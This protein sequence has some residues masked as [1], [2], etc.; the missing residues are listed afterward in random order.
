MNR[1]QAL[2]LGAL[3]SAGLA[4]PTSLH[5]AAPDLALEIAPVS[6]EVSPKRFLKTIGYNGQVPGPLLR[7]AEGRPVT[8]DVVNH[9]DAAEVVHWH[10]LSIPSEVDGAME[11]GTLMIAPGAQARYTFTPTP[12]GLRWYHSHAFAGKDLKRG[13]FSGQH[14]PMWID[15]KQNAGRYDQEVFLTL[16]DWDARMIGSD[17]GS[18]S[19]EY[20]VST[21][22]GRT[23][24]FGEPVRVRPGSVVLFHLVNS[25]ATD[26]HWLSLA[27]HRLRVVALDGNPVPQPCEVEMVRLGPAERVSATVTMNQ[28]GA[29]VF[30]EVRKHIQSAGMGIV[31]EYANSNGK[32]QWVQPESLHWDYL[33]FGAAASADDASTA[34]RVPLVFTS[35]FEG[36]GAPD[37]WMINGKSYPETET[38]MLR[39]GQ[40]YRLVMTNRSRDDHPIHL[41]RHRFELRRMAGVPTNGILKD[42]VMVPAGA[43]AEVEFLAD[44]PGA[45]LFHCHQQDHMDRGFMMLLRYR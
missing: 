32:P 23:L 15:P 28:P 5:A 9:S 19:P 10:G 33:Q 11:E 1:R 29:W 17:D 42:V 6:F 12:S 44:N 25:S 3:A 34:E 40:R 24:G 21:I 4:L 18:M 43:E 2:K 22:N 41:H 36:H 30:G 20:S 16:E 26:V 35:H 38:L 8:I 37:R 14:G 39:Q 31:V 7:F 27:G 13:L 45:T